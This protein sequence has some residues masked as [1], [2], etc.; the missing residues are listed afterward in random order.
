MCTTE[1]TLYFFPFKISKFQG[2]VGYLWFFWPIYSF[3]FSGQKDE[4][5]GQTAHTKR[6]AAT[7]SVKCGLFDPGL[8]SV[9]LFGGLPFFFSLPV[10]HFVAEPF[11]VPVDHW[12]CIPTQFQFSGCLGDNVQ[13][14]WLRIWGWKCNTVLAEFTI[15]K[16]THFQFFGW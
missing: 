14:S 6:P 11:W 15:N 1:K 12:R 4:Q 9:R 5:N 16:I 8:A 2:K 13:I 3:F 10:S 7:V